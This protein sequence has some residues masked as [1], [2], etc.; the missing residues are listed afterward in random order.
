[1]PKVRIGMIVLNEEEYLEKN[2]HQHYNSADEIVIVEGADAL[3]PPRSVTPDGLSTDK[4]AEI[5]RSFPDP[6]NKI[7]FIQHGWTKRGGANAKCELRNRYLE[8]VT[9]RTLLWVIDADEFYKPEEATAVLS[10]LAKHP[11]IAA[12]QIPQIHFW[13]NLSQFI[14]G[15]YYDVP[16]CRFWQIQPGD[17]YADNHNSPSRGSCQLRRMYT[18]V[19]YRE[20]VRADSDGEYV[21]GPVCYHTGFCK[22]VSNIQDKN[23]YYKNRGESRTR[24]ATVRSREAWFSED[25]D[26]PPDLTLHQFGGNLPGVLQPP[27]FLDKPTELVG[28]TVQPN[29]HGAA[30]TAR[31]D[32]APEPIES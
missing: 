1:M 24:R 10:T 15:G 12:Y 25:T 13:H 9:E 5:V 4:T 17:I 20:V 32:T 16:H 26:L 31:N 19:K 18:R 6:D 14:T 29:I 21:R 3:Y 22:K 30:N 7:R 8:G 2:L 28:T 23:R 27:A 11:K